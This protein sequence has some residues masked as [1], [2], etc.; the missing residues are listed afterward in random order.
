MLLDEIPQRVLIYDSA[1][2][3]KVAHSGSRPFK[4]I[5]HRILLV[6]TIAGRRSDSIMHFIHM[7]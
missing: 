4:E 3:V 6:I 2:D 5:L 7:R 1:P